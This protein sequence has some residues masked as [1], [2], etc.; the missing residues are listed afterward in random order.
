MAA[1]KFIDEVRLEGFVK[2]VTQQ[3][4]KGLAKKINRLD[5]VVDSRMLCNK[6]GLAMREA[7][8]SIEEDVRKANGVEEPLELYKHLMM[9]YFKPEDK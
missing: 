7:I 5:G 8:D 1:T 9:G 6:V 4:F 3:L 2:T